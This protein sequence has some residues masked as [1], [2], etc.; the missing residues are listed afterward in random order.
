MIILKKSFQNGLLYGYFIENN[1]HSTLQYFRKVKKLRS[2]SLI[3]IR[4]VVTHVSTVHPFAHLLMVL[5]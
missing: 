2:P 1:V 3:F 5:H 4:R